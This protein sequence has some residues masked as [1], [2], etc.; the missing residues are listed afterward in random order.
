MTSKEFS[1]DP[2]LLNKPR[3]RK[4]IEIVTNEEDDWF[5]HVNRLEKNSRKL[6]SSSVII[7]KDLDDWLNMLKGDGWILIN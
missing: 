1:K 2:I 6:T 3:S 5:L 4:I 7:R